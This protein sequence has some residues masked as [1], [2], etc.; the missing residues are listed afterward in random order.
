M[1][2]EHLTDE[3]LKQKLVADSIQ[4]EQYQFPTETIDLP[5]KGIVYPK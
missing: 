2:Q 1:T 3:E 5:S 4:S